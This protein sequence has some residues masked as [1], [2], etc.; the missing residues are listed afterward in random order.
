MVFAP[1]LTPTSTKVLD[2]RLILLEYRPV[3]RSVSNASACSRSHLQRHCRALISYHIVETIDLNRALIV[4]KENSRFPPIRQNKR[5][6]EC[7]P[8]KR[9]FPCSPGLER[10]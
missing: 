2:S 4:S 7:T 8:S 5:P 10:L 1:S 9:V 6:L 3:F